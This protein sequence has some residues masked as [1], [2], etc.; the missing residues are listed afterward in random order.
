MYPQKGEREITTNIHKENWFMKIAYR[1]Q[2]FST[3]K[4]ATVRGAPKLRSDPVYILSHSGSHGDGAEVPRGTNCGPQSQ[5]DSQGKRSD[6]I[7]DSD[8]KKVGL[9]AAAT[10]S[11]DAVSARR[12]PSKSAARRPPEPVG[13]CRKEAPN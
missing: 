11:S 3:E 7:A 9:S 1:I 10:G 12:K 8:C 4:A 2:W 6:L 13:V 5:R